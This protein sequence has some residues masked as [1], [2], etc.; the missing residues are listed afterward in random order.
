MALA[1]ASCDKKSAADPNDDKGMVAALDKTNSEP[2]KTAATQPVNRDPI[3][4]VVLDALD[5][6]KQERFYRLVDS[7]LQSPC[8]K[9]HSLRT[10]L[11]EDSECKRAPF[12]ARY[13]AAL[14]EDEAGDQE[15]KELYEEHYKERPIH[16][17]KLDGVPV[18]G[19][20][21]APVKMVEFYDYGCG[22]CKQFHPLL[23]EAISEYPS[24]VALFYKQFPLPAHKLSRGAAQA[25]RAA[26]KQGK[27]DQMHELLFAKAPSHTKEE[28][29]DYAK[30]LGLDMKRFAA[31]FDAAA[32]TVQ[33][34]VDEG[35]AAG[36]DGTPTLFINGREYSGPAHPRYLRLWFEEELAVNR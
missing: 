27:F 6:K 20:A 19:A 17:F 33:A 12:A 13:V 34:E 9:A 18:S 32:P 31:D 16:S 25:A 3:P 26:A 14:I 36:V 28:L 35:D 24:D 2:G 11:L 8:G 10:S 15:V 30:S 1:G 23:K 7:S 5:D 29:W 22:A 4:G 21:D